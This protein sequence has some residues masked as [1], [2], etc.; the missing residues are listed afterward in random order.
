MP[1]DFNIVGPNLFVG[2][3]LAKNDWSYILIESKISWHVTHN[4][5]QMARGLYVKSPSQRGDD[6]GD[7]II[8][9]SMEM[10]DGKVRQLWA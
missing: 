3:L 6:L 1:L 4:H 8:A 10:N 2:H 5:G 9:R 7:I